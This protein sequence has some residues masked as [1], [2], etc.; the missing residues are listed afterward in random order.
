MI[1]I[2]RPR[3]ESLVLTAADGGKLCDAE[4]EAPGGC[5]SLNFGGMDEWV[6]I[7]GV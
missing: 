2:T 4:V 5:I 3:I 6:E 7:P 1:R